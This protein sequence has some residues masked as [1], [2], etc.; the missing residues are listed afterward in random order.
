MTRKIIVLAVIVAFF[1]ALSNRWHRTAPDALESAPNPIPA[2]I[3][4][5]RLSDSSQIDLV[6]SG[7]DE[8]GVYSSPSGDQAQVQ[9]MLD[10]NRPH[11]SLGCAMVRGMTL[12]HHRLQ[13]VQTAD[14]DAVFDIA[15]LESP[16]SIALVASTECWR[17]RCDETSFPSHS[18]VLP[19]FDL[20]AM[21]VQYR[22][23]AGIGPVPVTIV[24]DADA[25]AAPGNADEAGLIGRFEKFAAT[26]D[27]AAVRSFA[28]PRAR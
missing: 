13:T 12:R 7:I 4:N 20:K 24:M 19:K 8:T 9:I 1:L 11:N 25:S 10:R 2:A 15:I 27:L 18:W 16:A 26:L 6:T 22:P 5:Y 17:D 28:A 23:A 3:G 21:F 14:S